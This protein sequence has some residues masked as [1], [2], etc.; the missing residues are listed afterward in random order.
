MFFA[1]HGSSR[2]LSSGEGF[3]AIYPQD[4]V[5][6]LCRQALP[7]CALKTLIT[8]KKAAAFVRE[9]V[10]E[11]RCPVCG[12][13]LC[14]QEEA[15]YGIC[16]NCSQIFA[17]DTSPRCISCGKPLISE[18]E[19]CMDCRALGEGEQFLAGGLL[20]YPY[21]ASF[22]PVL[23][24]Y[25]FGSSRT[26]A[27]FFALKTADAFARLKDKYGLTDPVFV[28]APPKPGKIRQTGWDQ[29]ESITRALKD[30]PGGGKI[31]VNRC[32]RRLSTVSQKKLKAS[33]RRV[34]LRGRILC[35]GPAPKTAV[36]FDDVRTTG[37]TLEA[38][39][40]AL[41][42]SGAEKVYALCLFY[43]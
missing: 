11:S 28:P 42:S 34:N 26:L 32:L 17:F 10:S 40:S 14:G 23:Q 2:M 15:W 5:L 1:K 35:A 18:R 37:A 29:V 43:N 16:E 41:R 13:P 38:C 30:V 21:S 6:A 24:A 39:A 19:Q 9:W 31:V 4:S 36:L 12:Q 3:C 7:I 22:R 20:L 8:L 25:K 27:R 33:E